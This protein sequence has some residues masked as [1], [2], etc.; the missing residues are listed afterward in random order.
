M[1]KIIA[2]ALIS[3]AFATPAF[4]EGADGSGF[5]GALDT[6]TWSLNSKAPGQDNLSMGF[7]I[8]GGYHFTRNWGAE[9]G[10]A[11]SGNGTINGLDYHVESTQLAAVGT[12]PLNDQFDLFAKLGVAA[13]KLAG[14][15]TGSKNDLLYGVGGQYNFNK[16]VGVRLQYEDIG[17]VSDTPGYDSK[18]SNIALG[19]AYNF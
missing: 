3:S 6:N 7:R 2:A 17:K 10:Y 1:R 15:T 14:N 9:L 19:L 18:A 8:A 4:A 11:Q 12:Y 13:N 5:Y 16:Q